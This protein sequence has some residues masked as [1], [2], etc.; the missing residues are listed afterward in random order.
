MKYYKYSFIVTKV[1][2]AIMQAS[3]LPSELRKNWLLYFSAL[4]TWSLIAYISLR[5]IESNIELLS[6]SAIFISF[7]VLFFANTT[8]T[9]V[10]RALRTKAF[11]LLQVLIVWLLIYLDKYSLAPILLCLI[12]SQL[13]GLYANKQ[14]A[15]I[16][17]IINA[18]F[19]FILT[20]GD[21][22]KG[23]F[24]V[25][26][27]FLLQ[28]FSFSTIDIARREK[29][30]REEITAINQELI[31]TRFMLKTSTKKQERLRIS[32]DLHDILGHQ[33]TALSLNLE[34]SVHKVPEEH[35]E[36]LSQNLQQAKNVLKNVR[37]VVKEMRNEDQFDLEN[38][39]KNLFENLPNCQLNIETPLKINSLA[40]KY[41][42]MYCL[43]EGVSNALRHGYANNFRLSYQK[44]DNFISIA[45]KDNGNGCKDIKLG[46]GLSGMNERL[47]EF[48]GTALLLNTEDH[49]CLLKISAQ[50]DF[51]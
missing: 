32:R 1:T 10:H 30:A 41:Q 15:V 50:D 45:L 23:I 5:K 49:H 48:N 19:Y 6:H 31:A 2:K 16:L 11:I 40:L 35:K 38:A 36:M 33:L 28:I 39:L 51:D 24:S 25:A 8:E 21:P 43:Q 29:A 9:R 42:L 44:L 17:L 26:I 18:G 13:P 20:N 7:I 4:L 27:F 34:V 46:S 14:V 22:N 47:A 37:S 12:S 3:F